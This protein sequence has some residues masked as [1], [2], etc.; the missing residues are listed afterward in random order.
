MGTH[1]LAR[2]AVVIL[3]AGSVWAAEPNASDM[4]ALGRQAAQGDRDAL[5]RME[6]IRDELYRDVDY[7][8]ESDRMRSNLVLMYAAFDEIA[9]SV[10]GNDQA[11]QAFQ[12]LLEATGRESL[13]SFTP[14]AFG[15]AAAQGHRPSLEVL[16]NHDE[17]GILLSS[18]VFALGKPAQEG[19]PEAI[20]FLVE[21]MDSDKCKALWH[22]ASRGLVRAA[23]EGNE[24]AR[25]VLHKYAESERERRRTKG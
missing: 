12:V 18:A 8:K 14:R 6:A 16:L 21:V 15:L 20:A 17:Y 19:S 24:E 11:D 1:L 3:A 13:R 22:G 4:R 9:G 5:S 10:R 2:A 23:N 7:A 25:R